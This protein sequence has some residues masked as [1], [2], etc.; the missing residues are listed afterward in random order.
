MDLA[1]LRVNVDAK[2]A[3][4]E[5]DALTGSMDKTTAASTR[6]TT[7]FKVAGAAGAVAA[8]YGIRKIV[9]ESKAA[10]YAQAQLE[11]GL[12]ST[13]GASRQTL[14]SLNAQSAALQR[15]T[16][17]SD[18]AVSGAQ[19][20]LLTFTR[21]GGDTFPR[22]TRAVADMAARMGG[23]LSSAA[24]QV[25]KALNDPAEALSAL[26]RAGVQFDKQQK[27]AIATMVRTNDIAGA[28]AII[29]SELERQF[30]GSAAAARNTLG[31]ALEGLN[32][33][34][35]EL[36]E[37]S[38]AGSTGM[39]RAINAIADNLP[40]I[41]G[42]VDTMIDG[43]STIFGWTNKVATTLRIIDTQVAAVAKTSATHADATAKAMERM[44]GGVT[45]GT[46][47]TGDGGLSERRA[48][49][50]ESKRMAAE[51]ARWEEEAILRS[52]RLAQARFAAENGGGP[53]APTF[54]A[55]GITRPSFGGVT[56]LPKDMQ[57][58]P[59]LSQA[60]AAAKVAAENA[61]AF[62]AAM[63]AKNAE[64]AKNYTENMQRAVGGFV[65][66][67]VSNGR[68]A[69]S[70]VWNVFKRIGAQA[71]G[72]TVSAAITRSMAAEAGG[73]FLSKILGP[74]GIG[75]AVGAFAVSGM[76]RRSGPSYTANRTPR[77]EANGTD[78]RQLAAREFL[79]G[80]TS[81]AGSMTRSAVGSTLTENTAS[82][83]FGTF[84]AMRRSLSNIEA[85][86]RAGAMGGGT[87]VAAM[88]RELGLDSQRLRLAAGVAVVA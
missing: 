35:G 68:L 64:I 75:L 77:Y 86:L 50:E 10:Q 63:T 25:G 14:A 81:T 33:A 16:T 83:L 78:P 9:E 17:Y 20:I 32:N 54:A 65:A 30:G 46:T 85:L 44:F 29:L 1:T 72:E 41:R 66:D 12:R 56:A 53:V 8:A 15:L 38:Q 58:A 62:Q 82:R 39:I 24:L 31:G 84:D 61:L 6:L 4:R 60:Q 27:D 52:V 71:I 23:D 87:S 80:N 73:G 76:T 40:K 51:R 43:Y 79:A 13:G 59:G 74:V 26:T 34:W 7:A 57:V 36:F 55:N 11:A 42:V 5:V 70:D 88:N 37:V 3:V 21:I 67:F 47:T 19:S 22:A 2:G 45:G 28:Q 49:W 48:A 69:V 18:E